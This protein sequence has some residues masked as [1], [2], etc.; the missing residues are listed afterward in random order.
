[1]SKF[2][3]KYEADADII[4]KGSFTLVGFVNLHKE[5]SMNKYP[6]PEWNSVGYGY[7]N[8]FFS[9]PSN[10]I[11]LIFANKPNTYFIPN[12]FTTMQF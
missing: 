9:S 5:L 10:L 11:I 7:L 12:I 8:S 2:Y 6:D 4:I 3:I 1:M